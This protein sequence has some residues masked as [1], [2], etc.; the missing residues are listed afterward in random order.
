MRR[1]LTIGIVLAVFQ[2]WCGINII[3]NYAQEIFAAAGYGISQTMMNIVVTGITNVVFTLVALFTVDRLGR[4][5]LL[6]LGAAG[7]SCAYLILSLAYFYG[8]TG[9]PMLAIVVVA[10]ACYSVSLAPV[11]WVVVSEIFPT[12]VRGAAMGVATFALWTACFILTYTFPM[13]NA[14]LGASGTFLL[15]GIICIAGLLFIIRCVPET[16]G[17]T[18]EEIERELVK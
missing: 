4:R 15:Y 11:M 12:A 18:L 6:L 3:F 17:K 2:Q 8:V 7:L 5:T 13:L 9:F 1:V 14:G 10:I 16:K